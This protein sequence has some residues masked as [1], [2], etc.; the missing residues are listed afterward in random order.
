MKITAVTDAGKLA[1]TMREFR[2]ITGKE[3]GESLKAHAR[4]ACIYLSQRTQPWG[5]TDKAEAQGSAAVNR[6]INKVY[7][8]ATDEAFYNQASNIVIRWYYAQEAKGTERERRA[9]LEQRYND[10]KPTKSRGDRI[11]SFQRRFKNYQAANNTDALAYIA[12]C[13]KF[14]RVLVNE[15]DP[16]Y[17]QRSRNSK[18]RVDGKAEKTLVIGVDSELNAYYNRKMDLVGLSKA[19]WAKCADAIPITGR[20]SSNV[21]EVPAWVKRN[22]GRASGH[23]QDNSANPKSPNVVM[24]NATPWASDVIPPKEAQ[25]ALDEATKN[26]QTYMTT[27]IFET[28]RKTKLASAA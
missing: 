7:Y 28:L 4:V 2:E 16:G 5:H 22:M 6:D 8:R 11:A 14:K 20:V 1:K 10:V 3:I 24:T 25:K 26:Y 15:F 18:G 17:H 13:F 21:R 19:G 27:Y 12:K 9:L 23:I